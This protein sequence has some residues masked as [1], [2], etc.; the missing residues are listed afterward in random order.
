M[1]WRL[2]QSV[3]GD[4]IVTVENLGE[5]LCWYSNENYVPNSIAI[6]INNIEYKLN[7]VLYIGQGYLIIPVPNNVFLQ[8]NNSVQVYSLCSNNPEF[9]T[10]ISPVKPIDFQIYNGTITNCQNYV[11]LT[12]DMKDYI[13]LFF[14]S[15]AGSYAKLHLQ[16]LSDYSYRSLSIDDF[17]YQSGD[18]GNIQSTLGFDDNYWHRFNDESLSSTLF[19]KELYKEAVIYITPVSYTYFTVRFGPIELIFNQGIITYINYSSSNQSETYLM[20]YAL[21]D[22][23]FISNQISI[24]T[25]AKVGVGGP[26]ILAVDKFVTYSPSGGIVVPFSATM[27]SYVIWQ[28]PEIAGSYVVNIAI[29]ENIRFQKILKVHSC[30]TAIQ[31]DFIGIINESYH[32]NVTLNDTI[33]NGESNFLK[34]LEG[35]VVGGTSVILNDNGEFTFYPI[36]DFEGEASFIYIRYC[37]TLSSYE[38]VGRAT[39]YINYD[40]ECISILPVWVDTTNRRCFNCFSQKEQIDTNIECSGSISPRWVNTDEEICNEDDDYENTNETKC[41]YG[42]KYLKQI[43]I[44]NCSTSRREKWLDLGLNIECNCIGEV[45]IDSC[46]GKPNFSVIVK[47]LQYPEEE[48]RVLETCLIPD[49]GTECLVDE[50]IRFYTVNDEQPHDYLV[51]IFDCNNKV[52]K[53]IKLLEYIC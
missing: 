40:N 49:L 50:P 23:I 51:T 34:V 30:G 22:Q 8:A 12:A 36:E 6:K 46:C 18:T 20:N 47:L 1:A 17:E 37:G 39:V 28:L 33:C 35:S 3:E 38:E 27:G 21:D 16:D 42:H 53:Q 19:S 4:R 13:R 45:F 48:N 5:P 7:S 44:N 2:R 32:G 15:N 29:N 52:I 43:N 26:A 9:R 14:P 41:E 25:V 10:N 31:D 24:Y 11:F